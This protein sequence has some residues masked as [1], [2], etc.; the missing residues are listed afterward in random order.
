MAVQGRVPSLALLVDVH[1]AFIHC[2]KCIV[3]SHLWEPGEWP[4]TG[5]LAGIRRAMKQHAKLE[6][7]LEELDEKARRDGLLDLY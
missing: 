2:P 1:T 5:D 6:G 4:E 7:T 3:R